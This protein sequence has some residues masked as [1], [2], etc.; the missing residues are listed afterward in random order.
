[1]DVGGSSQVA[2][3]NN[4]ENRKFSYNNNYKGKNPMTRTQWRRYQRLK[5]LEKENAHAGGSSNSIAHAGGNNKFVHAGNNTKIAHA[6]GN[7]NDTGNKQEYIPKKAE[8]AI[9][10]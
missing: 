2:S 6:G 3:S 7:R 1:M 9:I 4:A 10:I 8:K 5:K